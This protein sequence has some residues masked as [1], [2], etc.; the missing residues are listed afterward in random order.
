MFAFVRRAGA[1]LK[2]HAS[3]ASLH[4]P[5]AEKFTLDSLSFPQSTGTVAFAL[6]PIFDPSKPCVIA[7]RARRKIGMFCALAQREHPY[8]NTMPSC[9]L[10]LS[11]H[12]CRQTRVV[13][14]A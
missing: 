13:C 8:W 3:R 10:L 2:L 9:A 5:H 4:H 7:L 6:C 14:I 1:F 12:L 11:T